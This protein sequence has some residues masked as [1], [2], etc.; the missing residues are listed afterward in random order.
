WPQNSPLIWPGTFMYPVNQKWLASQTQYSNEP[1]QGSGTRG[2]GRIYYHSGLDLGG[3]ENMVEVSSATDG[4]VVSARGEVLS[5]EPEE[6]ISPRYDVVYVR[7]ARG[8]YYRYSHLAVIEPELQIGQRIRAGD[9]IGMLGKEGASGG[10]SHLHFE[11]KSIQPSGRW[12]TQE[13]YA[14]LWQSYVQE[15]DPV[16]LPNARPHKVVHAGQPVTLS[17][18]NSWAKNDITGY[19]WTLS[20]GTV[21]DGLTIE[22]VYN[23]PGTYSEILKI[24]DV[25]GNYGFDVTMVKVYEQGSTGKDGLPRIHAASFPSFNIKPGDL[26]YFQ[27][28]AFDTTE[29]YD[30]WNFNDGSKEV[31]VKSNIDAENHAKVGYSIVSH[32]YREAGDYLVKVHRETPQGTAT[33]HLH[34][35]VEPN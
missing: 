29:G 33:T 25:E 20:D 22:Q 27:V 17:A 9:K 5:G 2:D 30:V 31:T 4:V 1:V 14:F 8:W 19:E 15:Y 34:V 10:W 3:A 11:I 18:A 35:K 7:D 21:K 24:T 26:I 28:R 12:G 13:G 6:P 16:L 32:R 23:E